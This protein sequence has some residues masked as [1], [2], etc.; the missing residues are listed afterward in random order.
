VIQTCAPDPVTGYR[1]TAF[2][3]VEGT[4]G[5]ASVAG[6]IVQHTLLYAIAGND[7]RM[8]LVF[9]H[10]QRKLTGNAVPVENQ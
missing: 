10:R 3:D 8:K 6:R 2:G 4:L 7:V 9:A 5:G 1:Q